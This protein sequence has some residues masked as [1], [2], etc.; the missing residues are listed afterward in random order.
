MLHVEDD[1]NIVQIS[2]S[3]LQDIAAYHQ[4]GGLREAR[5]LLS[6]NSFDLVLLDLDLADG[7]G[8]ELLSDLNSRCPIIIF[9]AQA[10]KKVYVIGYIAL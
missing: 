6:S 5:E 4:A 7:D 8:A 9:S 3:L 1:L 2:Q 10:P